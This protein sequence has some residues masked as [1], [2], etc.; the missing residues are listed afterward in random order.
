[1]VEISFKSQNLV[2]IGD[3]EYTKIID[4]KKRDD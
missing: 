2:L 1:M 4:K 3:Y